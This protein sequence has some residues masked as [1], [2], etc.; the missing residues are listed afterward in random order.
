MTSGEPGTSQFTEGEEEVPI[1]LNEYI[2]AETQLEEDARAVLGSSDAQNCSYAKVSCRLLNRVYMFYIKSSLQLM[3][4]FLTKFHS[5]REGLGP[6]FVAMYVCIG[7]I[8][9]NLTYP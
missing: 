9:P 6:S 5:S 3:V 2:E 8:W 7:T 4:P 1:S